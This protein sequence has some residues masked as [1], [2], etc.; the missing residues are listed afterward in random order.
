MKNLVRTSFILLLFVSGILYFFSCSQTTE[1]QKAVAPQGMHSLDLSTYG[2]PFVIFVPDTSNGRLSV[3]ELTN[4]ML[5]VKVGTEFAIG[6]TEQSADLSLIKEDLKLDEVNKLQELVK[7]DESTLI[8][9]SQIV[10]PEF[11]FICNQKIKDRSFSFEDVR[12]PQ[13]SPFTKEQI[14]RMY[15]SAKTT[16]ALN[17]KTNS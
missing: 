17:K 6:I 4:G 8:W 5:E 3:N 12:D 14:D 16:V 1:E 2:K 9:K 13:A 11:H 15:E 7:D 10:E